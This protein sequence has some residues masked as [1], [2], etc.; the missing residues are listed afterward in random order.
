M[1][2]SAGKLFRHWEAWGAILIAGLCGGICVYVGQQLAH[3]Y[4]GLAIGAILGGLLASR[5]L[6]Y[7]VRRYELSD[8]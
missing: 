6:A 4:L 1:S 3:P 8:R 2:N 7:V 5:I